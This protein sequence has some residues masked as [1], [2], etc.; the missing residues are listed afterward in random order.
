MQ[1]CSFIRKDQTFLDP[2]FL[3]LCGELKAW[4]RNRLPKNSDT[5]LWIQNGKECFRVMEKE[6][7]RMIYRPA[8]TGEATIIEQCIYVSTTF[9]DKIIKTYFWGNVVTFPTS[10]C[11]SVSSLLLFST[12][13]WLKNNHSS[14]KQFE[15]K[16]PNIWWILAARGLVIF[17]ICE[18]AELVEK[19]KMTTCRLQQ[20]DC[21]LTIY[22][23]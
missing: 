13:Q 15:D 16:S 10:N 14:V 20:N 11:L 9:T 2:V 22:S 18:S 5:Q 17:A 3:W 21:C 19:R 23:S 4:F 8:A 6:Q 12:V 1:S 7:R